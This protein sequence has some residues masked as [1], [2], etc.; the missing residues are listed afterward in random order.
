MNEVYEAK[1]WMGD[2]L[3]T[4]E[5]GLLEKKMDYARGKAQKN[6]QNQCSFAETIFNYKDAEKLASMWSVTT[7]E[8]KVSLQ[9]KYLYGL[10][11]SLKE[12][13]NR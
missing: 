13:L 10:E 9:N 7:A 6:P 8:A 4:G 1:V 2:L 11:W 3:R 5:Q 12:Q